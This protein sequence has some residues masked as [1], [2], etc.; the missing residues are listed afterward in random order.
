MTLM[1]CGGKHFEIWIGIGAVAVVLAFGTEVS[2]VRIGII[3][4]GWTCATHWRIKEERRG[5]CLPPYLE[6]APPFPLHLSPLS[7][8]PFFLNLF[9]LLFVFRCMKEL[10]CLS[11]IVRLTWGIDSLWLPG[12]HLFNLHINSLTYLWHVDLP[13]I[14]ELKPHQ[15]PFLY[16]SLST[17]LHPH[18]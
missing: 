17:C 10:P 14:Q 4:T 8:A 7:C 12:F 13:F 9:F 18:C 2:P 1:W 15:H 11:K 16:P 6:P 5:F 3:Q